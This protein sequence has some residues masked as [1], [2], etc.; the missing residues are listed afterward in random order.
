MLCDLGW[1]LTKGC[2]SMRRQ[3]C[4]SEQL[5]VAHSRHTKRLLCNNSCVHFL[6]MVTIDDHKLP[7]LYT[8]VD[9]D[10]FQPR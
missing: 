2:M 8:Q 5:V 1:N 6:K 9:R 10:G 7:H 4:L 3:K